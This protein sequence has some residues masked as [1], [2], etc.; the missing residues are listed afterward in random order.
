MK[1]KVKN[2][3]VD[4]IAGNDGTLGPLEKGRWLS[5]AGDSVV[6]D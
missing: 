5:M 2:S 3:G 6:R 4:I 1:I